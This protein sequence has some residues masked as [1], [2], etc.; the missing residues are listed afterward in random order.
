MLTSVLIV[1]AASSP[2]ATSVSTI[3]RPLMIRAITAAMSMCL[4]SLEGCA[5]SGGFG[6]GDGNGVGELVPDADGADLVVVRHKLP[7]LRQIERH[8]SSIDLNCSNLL[9]AIGID[10]P[11]GAQ[12][13]PCVERDEHQLDRLLHGIEAIAGDGVGNGRCANLIRGFDAL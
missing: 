8:R 1:G 9:L 12:F 4:R 6:L 11:R 10:L 13:L 5:A 3:P 7:K 2:A